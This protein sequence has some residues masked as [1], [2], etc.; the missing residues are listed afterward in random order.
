[1]KSKKCGLANKIQ[2][3]VRVA[4]LEKIR[5]RPRKAIKYCIEFSSKID[6]KPF[7]KSRPMAFAAKL[8]KKGSPG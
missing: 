7:K 4:M 6:P 8:D 2:C 1:M 5:E 3:F